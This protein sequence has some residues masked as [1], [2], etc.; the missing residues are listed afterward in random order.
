LVLFSSTPD[1]FGDPTHLNVES[2]AY[3]STLFESNGF[4]RD[5]AADASYLAPQAVLYRRSDVR[6]G[7]VVDGYE[8]L[9]RQ[10]T[11]RWRS[12]YQGAIAEHDA[13]AE[14]FN[15]SEW[16][17]ESEELR[18]DLL[19]LELRRSAE[20]IAA[21][22]RLFEYEKL[23][24]EFAL[25]LSV[26]L[27]ELNEAREYI[28]EVHRTRIYRYTHRLRTIYFRRRTAKRV[29]KFSEPA[30][31]TPPPRASYSL[32]IDS[33]DTLDDGARSRLTA[34]VAAIA[35][36]PLISILLPVYNTPI[37]FLN[38]AVS[39]VR[40]Q[41]Y[42]HW[43]LCIVDDCSTDPSIPEMLEE[44]AASDPRI[45]FLRRDVNGHI[46]AASNTALSMAS[47]SWVACLDHD[48]TLAETALAHFALTI[49]A[50]PRAEAIYSDEDKISQ[51][52]MREDPFFK[53]DFD[54]TLLVGQNYMCHLSM[55]RKHLVDQAGGFRVGYEGSQDWD[56][57]LRVTEGLS[58]EQIL[59][60]P[61]I[62]YHWRVHPLSTAMLLSAKAYAAG[63]GAR[64]ARDHVE[65]IEAE[66]DV[67]P[68]PSSGWNR[69]KW[70]VP[71]P[72]PLVSIVI[73]TR[74]G[75]LLSRCID[76]IRHRSTYPNVEIVVV[77]NGSLTRS[78]LEYLRVNE[79]WLTVIRDESPFNYPDINNRAV[80]Q[81][82][83]E[84]ICLLNDDTEI[85]N[86][87]WL[88]EMVGQLMR[89]A[90]GAV[91]AKLYY[92][93][94]QVQ[95]AGVILGIGSVAGHLY[96]TSDRLATGDHGRIQLPHELS[97][98]T[99][100]CM[101]VRRNAW[102]QVGGMDGVNLPV[103]F[104]D[105]DLCLRLREAGWK[106]VWTP[107]AELIHHESISRGPDTEGERALRFGREIHY[108]KER[109]GEI[110]RNDPAYNPNLT[111]TSEHC[112]LAWPPRVP[113]I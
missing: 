112:Q 89:P 18:R 99:A 91:G 50:S 80:S 75:N 85:L 47:G 12:L 101:V 17:F 43:E 51:T 27:T 65:R 30:P 28:E 84:V 2:P 19:Q 33:Y 109:W 97:A 35:D 62:L 29:P 70:R 52:G 58:A 21:R 1:E 71:V 25:N 110:L 61:R 40:T 95:H 63:S 42:T 8:R 31:D 11:Q 46:S 92:G 24:D 16:R 49:D 5:F 10:E 105:I 87:D 96:R 13:L 67:I 103:A 94:G 26:A 72:P 39:S 64:S 14:R 98:V 90:V 59:H 83:G 23:Q 20:A 32:W 66:G 44:F 22:D 36:P 15:A 82:R 56:L 53:P 93:N 34:L 111:L 57:A 102:E 3:W 73:P 68:L 78:T 106:I 107:Y 41:I 6:V 81:S 54:R 86:G 88:D 79:T 74:D 108:M 113:R 76:S 48:D 7:E 69:V 77:D 100:A 4:I 60:I 55:Y 9:L 104:N 37:D 38:E 45:K